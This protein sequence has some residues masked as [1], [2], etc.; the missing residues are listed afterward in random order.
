MKYIELTAII[1]TTKMDPIYKEEFHVK[2]RVPS[3]VICLALYVGIMSTGMNAQAANTDGIGDYDSS[4]ENIE[5]SA[6]ANISYID[7]NN[8]P[9]TLTEPCT[10]VTDT[11]T[12]WTD[13][14]YVVNGSVEITSSVT[15]TG[16]VKLLLSDGAQLNTKNIY[17]NQNNTFS[18]YCQSDETGS[19]TAKSSSN[20]SPGIGASRYNNG[21]NINIY[22]GIIYAQGGKEGVNLTNN[23]TI[24]NNGIIDVTITLPQGEQ[25]LS[26][27]ATCETAGTKSVTLYWT[28]TTNNPVSGNANYYPWC[29]KAHM[30]IIPMEGY[31]LTDSTNVS[32]NNESV[33]EKTL[34]TDGTLKVANPYYSNQVKLISFTQP[35]DITGVTNGTEKTVTALG[36]PS[37][38]TVAT[39]TTSIHSAAVT[40]DLDNLVTGSY[41]PA[42][43]TEQTFRVKGTVSLPEEINN[44]DNISLEIT[45]DVT[46]AAHSCTALGD[47]QYDEDS[48]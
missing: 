9:A 39:E 31:I 47:W 45:I 21:G 29:Y 42:K 26:T 14:W 13:G 36:L 30:T 11:T 43:L 32:V 19:L 40:W 3:S 15:V 44:S 37:T 7:E 22:G 25:P 23:G 12:T 20:V 27:D 34:D 33:E 8:E 48:H 6:Q 2:K 5:L 4:F 35:E 38:V 28:D 46:V 17:V 41:D 10:T 18:V 16:D 1:I 24:V